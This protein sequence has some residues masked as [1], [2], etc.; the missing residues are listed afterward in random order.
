[1]PDNI[2]PMVVARMTDEEV[3]EALQHNEK[4]VDEMLL[5]LLDGAAK[6]N[7]PVPGGEELRA[8][9]LARAVPEPPAGEVIEEIVMEELPV[10]YSQT[11]ILAFTIF[12]SPLFGGVLLAMNAS[13][14]KSKTVWQVV[15]F[16]VVLSVI[17]GFISWIL[18]PGS[19]VGIL[20]PVACGLILS[21]LAWN[22]FIGKGVPYLHRRILW[23]LIIAL[24]ITLPIGY[25]AYQHPELFEMSNFTN[26]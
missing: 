8:A 13:R 14:M 18:M 10:L 20:V 24:A 9:I 19:F 6:R 2:Y 1:M 25:Y 4:Y 21:E 5:A 22:R 11:A 23:P 16:S 3:L 26:E 7:L 15:V 17:S 12:F